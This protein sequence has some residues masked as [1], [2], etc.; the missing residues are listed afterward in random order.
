[1]PIRRP[2]RNFADAALKATNHGQGLVRWQFGQNR[3][4]PIARD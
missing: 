2:R 3:D 1:M 4:A